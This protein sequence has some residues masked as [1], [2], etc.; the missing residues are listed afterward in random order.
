MSQRERKDGRIMKKRG[1]EMLQ[2]LIVKTPTAA[3]HESFMS[4]HTIKS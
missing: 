3:S 1:R 2:A 4:N